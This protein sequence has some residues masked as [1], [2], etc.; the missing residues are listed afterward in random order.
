MV[1]QPSSKGATRAARLVVTRAV[2]SMLIGGMSILLLLLF[3][4]GAHTLWFGRAT[5]DLGS[6]DPRCLGKITCRHT[7]CAVLQDDGTAFVLARQHNS[8]PKHPST[9]LSRPPAAQT[10]HPS[11][12]LLPHP[13]THPPLTLRSLRCAVLRCVALCWPPS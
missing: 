3:T 4:T 13:P 5:L 7:T 1:H 10:A 11:P 12:A 8:S 6:M 2:I 9:A